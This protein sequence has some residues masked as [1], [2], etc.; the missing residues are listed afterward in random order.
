VKNRFRLEIAVETIEA[1]AAAE[2][3]GADRVELCANLGVGGITPDRAMLRA[4]RKQIRIPLFVMIRP[5]GGNFIYS[6]VEFEEMRKSI[7]AAK[8]FGAS[9]IVLGILTPN[10]EVDLGRTRDLV[11][12]A[13]PLPVTFHRA[14]D[15]CA[16]IEKAL[17]DVVST[18]ATRILT[19]G[20]EPT[21]AKGAD[22]IARL[23]KLADERLTI[24][25]GAGI[26]AGNTPQVASA[27]GA[28]EFHSG[29]SSVLSYPRTDHRQFENEV[30]RMAAALN[31]LA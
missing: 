1:A 28:K 12:S 21:A 24:V 30:R 27:T 29:L 7:T 8:D 4:V 22:K 9:G 11:A 2:R 5:R 20:G 3:G 25:P 31:S 18:G 15:A 23:V 17:G 16:N 14:F 10:N 26:N 19:S 13:D 6:S